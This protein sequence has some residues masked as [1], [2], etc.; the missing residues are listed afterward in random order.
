MNFIARPR[1]CRDRHG[2]LRSLHDA[3]QIFAVAALLQRLGELE[4]LLGVDEALAPGDLLDARDFQALPLLDDA[5]E[6]A[7][8]EQRIVGAGIEPRRAASQSLDVQGA[9]L[10]VHAIE[11]R[12]L[13]LPARRRLQRSGESAARVS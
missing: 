8:I 3:H 7:R 9:L 10:E 5:H 6:H 1:R 12:D 13:E 11:V 4:Q 2:W